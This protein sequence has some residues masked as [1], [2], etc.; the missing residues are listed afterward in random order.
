MAKASDNPYPS[1]LVVEGTTPASPPAGDQRVFID[2]ADHKLKRVN[3]SGTVTTIESS[4]SGL[5]AI[6]VSVLTVTSGDKTLL[7]TSYTA[8][9]TGGAFDITIAASAGDILELTLSAILGS[10]GQSTPN[11]VAFTARTRVASAD[12]NTISGAS[13]SVPGWFAPDVVTGKVA[14]I[15]GSAFYTV[16]SGD[17]SS[18]NVTLRLY[19]KTDVATAGFGRTMFADTSNPSVFSVKNLKH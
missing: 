18:G 11:N 16:V 12:V 9:D 13:A 7:A 2:S 15:S 19:Y 10:D 3:S 4:G 5:T 1:V 14:V 8:V 17:I 6:P